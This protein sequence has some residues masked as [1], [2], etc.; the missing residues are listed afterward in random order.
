MDGQRL[1]EVDTIHTREISWMDFDNLT[2]LG[3][4]LGFREPMLAELFAFRSSIDFLEITADH[5]FDALPAKMAELDLLQRNFPL[6]PHGLAMSLGSAEGLDDE[7]VKAY[8]QVVQRVK[9]V[10]CSEHIAFTRSDGIDVGHLLPLPK[11]DASL[12]VLHNNISR[13]QDSLQVPLI[14]ENITEMFRYPDERYDG[15]DFLC[16]LCEQNDIGLLLDVTNLFINAANQGWDPVEHLRRLPTDRIVQLHFVGGYVEDG[17]WVD[18]H[19]L[20]TNEEIW[21][22]MKS[23]FQVTD[24]K[25]CILERDEHIPSLSELVSELDRARGLL[26]SSKQLAS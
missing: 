18:S 23:V 11:T 26:T 14:L 9:P 13:L 22:L 12:R 21:D 17:Q 7:Y 10:W 1:E 3:V 16:K 20:A 5:Y 19:S 25:G 6:I 4:G 8:T 24:V 15:A 2:K